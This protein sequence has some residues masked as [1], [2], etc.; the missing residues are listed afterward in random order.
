MLRKALLPENGGEQ[1]SVMERR[2][3]FL[4]VRGARKIQTRTNDDP[5]IHASFHLFSKLRFAP[6]VPFAPLALNLSTVVLLL[7]NLRFFSSPD[8]TPCACFIYL[9]AVLFGF[10]RFAS[11]DLPIT[12]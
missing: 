3:R 8:R 4:V 1:A 2:A 9:N 10:P 7:Q 11:T 6:L 12:S 5:F